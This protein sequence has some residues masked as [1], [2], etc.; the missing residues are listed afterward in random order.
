MKLSR[1]FNLLLLLILFG[2]GSCSKG[3]K[4][5]PDTGGP[6]TNNTVTFATAGAT[7]GT[8][9]I[10][11]TSFPLTASSY[12]ITVGGKAVTLIKL[13][14][15]K[16]GFIMPLVAQGAINVDLAS[17]GLKTQSY[18]VGAYTAITQPQQVI[19]GFINDLNKAVT[20][21]ETRMTDTI[22]TIPA[23]KVNLV[24]NL[25]ANFNTL[26]ATMN[27]EEKQELAYGLQK[28]RFNFSDPLVNGRKVDN[29]AMLRDPGDD[30]VTLGKVVVTNVTLTVSAIS[31]SILGFYA[32]EPTLLSKVLGLAAGAYAAAS[33]AE[34]LR[35][36]E[37]L[38]DNIGQQGNFKEYSSEN[39]RLAP[40]TATDM[41][42][43]GFTDMINKV[44][45]KFTFQSEFRSLSK[46]DASRGND[47]VNTLFAGIDN[48]G[49]NYNKLVAAINYA[50]SWFSDGPPA[51]T[52]FVSPIRTVPLTAI[53]STPSDNIT[54]NNVSVTDIQVIFVK[55]SDNTVTIKAASETVKAVKDF[56]FDVVYTN[57]QLG[58]SNKL[59]V[60]ATFQPLTNEWIAKL[61]GTWKINYY[62]RM[63]PAKYQEYVDAYHQDPDHAG[64]E[65]AGNYN[66]LVSKIPTEITFRQDSTFGGVGNYFYGGNQSV[67]LNSGSKWVVNA[68]GALHCW[69]PTAKDIPDFH[70]LTGQLE[71]IDA[72]TIKVK[73]GMFSCDCEEP[74]TILKKK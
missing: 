42:K 12:K 52:P 34:T 25:R 67:N 23:E 35:L 56:S 1:I 29:A 41:A 43:E 21:L 15:K 49:E 72:T 32:P 4:N 71:V 59:K 28:F 54:I 69:F 19:D 2:A 38:A 14:E 8:Q 47:F 58:I 51:L 16:A 55:N 73:V 26:Y 50:K 11:E 53:R 31:I 30:I 57:A 13:E 45:L 70:P 3:S 5:A 44:P 48:L 6:S 64:F 36:T 37:K 61:L 60:N 7:P 65:P 9:V 22:Q 68:T 24:K 39:G 63:S 33:F 66:L 27:A 20:Q 17:L 18:T 46:Q 62:L 40:V 10:L 74:Y